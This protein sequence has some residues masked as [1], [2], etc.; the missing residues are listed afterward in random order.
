MEL[1]Q[2]HNHPHPLRRAAFRSAGV[3]AP[4]LFALGVVLITWAE[5]DLLRGLGFTLTAHGESAWP[6]GLAQ[7]P[8]GWA[9]IVNSALFGI[10]AVGVLRQSLWPVH[11]AEAEAFYR[12]PPD[13][14]GDWLDAG[15]LPRGRSDVRRADH[16][17]GYLHGVGFVCI[18]LFGMTGMVAT[19]VA[20]RRNMAWRG[21]SAI[22]VIAVAAFFF[23]F[24]LVVRS[25]GRDHPQSLRM[26][27]RHRL[28]GRVDGGAAPPADVA[29]GTGNGTDC[30]LPG[31]LVIGQTRCWPVVRRSPQA[32]DQTA[33]AQ[34]FCLHLRW[35]AKLLTTSCHAASRSHRHAILQSACH[36]ARGTLNRS[37]PEV[38]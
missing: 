8:V 33:Q 23:L 1:T 35:L 14:L 11:A 3:A 22:S 19:G 10:P 15:D 26:L 36:P 28:M 4:A 6:S 17:G 21:Y 18:V 32:G 30:T 20:L 37:P 5:W 13:R 29:S 31:L 9:Q 25:G 34:A 24:V 16:L 7:G 12:H 2:R 38:P 27:R